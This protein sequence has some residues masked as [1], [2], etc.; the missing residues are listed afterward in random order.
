MQDPPM[1]CEIVSSKRLK[2][3]KHVSIET[4]DVFTAEYA[5]RQQRY[6]QLDH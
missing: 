6:Y 3:R 4:V 5:L 2:R 1:E